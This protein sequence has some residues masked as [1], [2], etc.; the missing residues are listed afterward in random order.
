MHGERAKSL[1]PSD[2]RPFKGKMMAYHKWSLLLLC[3]ALAGKCR[4]S[5]KLLGV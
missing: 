3:D 5:V 4:A 1:G 2:R